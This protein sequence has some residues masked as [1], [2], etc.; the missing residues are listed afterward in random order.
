MVIINWL[1]GAVG[2]SVWKF[3]VSSETEGQLGW[4]GG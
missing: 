3:R 2:A 1:G 4:V